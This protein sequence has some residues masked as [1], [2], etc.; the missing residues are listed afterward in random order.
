MKVSLDVCM[1]VLWRGLT[2]KDKKKEKKE[3]YFCIKPLS[4]PVLSY[5][6]F[7]SEIR[8]FCQVLQ[9]ENCALTLKLMLKQH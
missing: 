7:G 9:S 6:C 4:F 1:P 3:K 5:I 2:S 8:L